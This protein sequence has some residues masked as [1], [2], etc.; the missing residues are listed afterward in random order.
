LLH[1]LFNAIFAFERDGFEVEVVEDED[2]EI[3]EFLAFEG[4]GSG[5]V[6]AA[7]RRAPP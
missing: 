2:L 4:V 5:N 1:P 7:R 3:V 6:E